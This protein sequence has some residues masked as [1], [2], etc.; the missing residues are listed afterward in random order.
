MKTNKKHQTIHRHTPWSL[1]LAV[2]FAV[3]VSGLVPKSPAE[4]GCT[5][6]CSIPTNGLV[7]WWRGESNALDSVGTSHAVFPNGV[8]YGAGRCG[9]AFKLDGMND[10]GSISDTNTLKPANLTVSF[11]FRLAAPIGAG[12]FT[13]LVAK[14]NGSYQTSCHGYD[15]MYSVN[16]QGGRRLELRFAIGLQSPARDRRSDEFR[17]RNRASCGGHVRRDWT[18]GTKAVR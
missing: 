7:A 17:H 13:P 11:W 2:F 10:Y 4:C 1:L 8:G 5:S 9:T 14:I 3:C 15:F 18:D 12:S 16:Q 6:F